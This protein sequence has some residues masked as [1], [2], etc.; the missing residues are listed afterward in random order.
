MNPNEYIETM[1]HALI[2]DNEGED[3]QVWL[4]TKSD[5]T[6]R[7]LRLMAVMFSNLED[8]KYI[9]QA[10]RIKSLLTAS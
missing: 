2:L 9:A 6:L 4:S 7:N 1:E 8:I 3:G 5:M 10:Q